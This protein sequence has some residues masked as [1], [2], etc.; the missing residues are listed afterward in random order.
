MQEGEQVRLPARVR[1]PESR[2]RAAL[3]ACP[4]PRRALTIPWSAS[5]SAF[6]PS[7]LTA[8]DRTDRLLDLCVDATR[9]R[10]YT[11]S[12]AGVVTAYSL[13]DDGRQFATAARAK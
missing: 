9:A 1:A 2:P 3:R 8:L 5:G 6:I 13:G 12:E 10:L 7:F 4:C 11:L